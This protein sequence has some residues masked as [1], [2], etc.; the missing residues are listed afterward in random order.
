MTRFESLQIQHRNKGNVDV[1]FGQ[2]GG[3]HT[4]HGVR[5]AV[6]SALRS[7]TSKNNHRSYNAGD[8]SFPA[9]EAPRVVMDQLDIKTKSGDVFLIDAMVANTLKVISE[10]G[11]IVGQ[12][13]ANKRIEME[14]KLRIILALKSNST[15]D[16]ELKVSAETV[17]QVSMESPYYGH[18][19]LTTWA[20]F[21]RPEL[22][23]SPEYTFVQQTRT[24]QTLTG[25][26]SY[27]DA[28]GTKPSGLLPKVRIGGER[29]S[30]TLGR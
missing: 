19:S 24:M 22:F 16:L 6:E 27:P 29:A 13:T 28:N 9:P 23:F 25:Y 8:A 18:M 5:T 7:S 26:F 21:F 11:G 12:V 4:S 17:A 30:F 14:S 15:S 10:Q 2:Y 3:N 1:W 20:S